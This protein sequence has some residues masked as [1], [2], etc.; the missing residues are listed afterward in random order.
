MQIIQEHGKKV[1][2]T[3]ELN[4]AFKS[5]KHREMLLKTITRA[6]EAL[7]TTSE[8]NT[9]QAL[10]T[11]MEA[12]GTSL[13]VDRVQIWRN[14]EVDGEFCF[15][16][17][18]EWLSEVGK[19]KTA[20]P[21]GLTCPYDS[22]P[23]WYEMFLRGDYINGPIS[24]LSP[25]EEAFLGHYEM[26]SIVIYPLVLNDHF[27]GFFSVD[28]CRKERV[29]TG[30]EM[31]LVASAGLMFTSV[32][33]RA[34]RR[35][36]KNELDLERQNNKITMESNKA[37]TRFLARMSHEIRTPITAILGISE[38]QLYQSLP[39]AITE[40]F[41]KIHNSATLLL[42]I[43][44][45]IL[46][47]SKLEAEKMSLKT[48]EYTLASVINDV[49]NMHFAFS[50]E[51]SPTFKLHVDENLPATLNGDSLRIKQILSNLLSNAFK[52]TE[53]GR[54][55][56]FWSSEKIEGDNEKI[57]IVVCIK[58]SGL[59]MTKEQLASL[60]EEYT[61]FHESENRVIEGT[62]LGMPIV[63][64]LASLMNAKIDFESEVGVGTTVTVRIPQNV[65][66]DEVLG[67]DV[68]ADLSEFS[69]KHSAKGKGKIAPEPMPYGKV[70]VVDDIDANIYVIQGLLNFY[71]LDIETCTSGQAAIDKISQ[72]KI[73]DLVFM[74]QMMP[75]LSG[76]ETLIQI[77]SLGYKKPVIMLTAD[78]V[79]G[80][81]EE[82]IN[83]GFDGFITKP[84]DT[85]HLNRALLKFVR[86]VQPPEV[87]AAALT[88]EK[89][90][91]AENIDDFQD[92][93][94][95][96][97]RL[98]RS[99]IRNHKNTMADLTAALNE[100][101]TEAAYFIAHTIKGSAGTIKENK[102]GLLSE[103]LSSALKEGNIPPARY[104]SR[105]E[106]ELQTVLGKITAAESSNTPAGVDKANAIEILN[107]LKPLLELHS[108]K[109]LQAAD[110]LR[111]IPEAAVLVKMID[112]FDFGGA[113]D[114]ANILAD[115]FSD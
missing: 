47:L 91:R 70:L 106:K 26:V 87:I 22:V 114:V 44:N 104:V 101:N 25:S 35:K 71:G 15:V 43:I 72:G 82:Y 16:M 30:A 19:A 98:Q 105:F 75:E 113:L 40:S 90:V 56:M 81:E 110:K 55:E 4:D 67:K 77:R 48:K 92:N 51:K 1:S 109:C 46:D 37:K 85:R 73:Y 97:N 18:Y 14:E 6:A 2:I 7:L 41:E 20:V 23:G 68:I 53:A 102:L 61:R 103:H 108:P 59:G 63:Y 29:L 115:L 24:E 69:I 39:P 11:S 76:T 80:K 65:I 5:L 10:M 13:D 31:N 66:G 8:E 42:Q 21:L 28:D 100:K 45:D 49:T 107:E 111:G 79:S 27:I 83:S 89:P 86:D 50:G 12:V 112:S 9:L 60:S 33:N 38:I 17:R 94:D 74:D 62:G 34:E 96:I 52:Y 36:L 57:H 3:Q 64:S 99:F 54:V 32:F 78:A 88:A 84:V 93:E 95:L 58:D